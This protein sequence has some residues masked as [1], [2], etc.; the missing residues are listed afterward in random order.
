[1]D[2]DL[3]LSCMVRNVEILYS[4]KASKMFGSELDKALPL[5]VNVDMDPAA[6]RHS[7]DHPWR[8]RGGGETEVSAYL[9]LLCLL[10]S[11]F[12]HDLC[13]LEY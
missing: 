7:G 8:M 9:P 3:E 4:D 13:T 6:R 11:Q 12:S 10:R 5:K 2:D 1:M